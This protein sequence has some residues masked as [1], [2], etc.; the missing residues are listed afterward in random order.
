MKGPAP[1]GNANAGRGSAKKR[2]ASPRSPTTA[3][4]SRS[5]PVSVNEEAGMTIR[6]M[7]RPQL[8]QPTLFP[9]LDNFDW[10]QFHQVLGAPCRG[11]GHWHRGLLMGDGVGCC[12]HCGHAYAMTKPKPKPKP[13]PTKRRPPVQHAVVIQRRPISTP[14][15]R[16]ARP[17]VVAAAGRDGDGARDDGG[18][19]GSDDGPS[20]PPP[21][22]GH[23]PSQNG[24]HA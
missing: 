18:G 5:S 23:A 1:A 19:G 13:E 24:R 22:R 16:A 7:G 10:G 12:E 9:E 17:Q 11:C 6:T 3:D 4:P 21:A 15:R 20:G 2:D 14:R 8:A